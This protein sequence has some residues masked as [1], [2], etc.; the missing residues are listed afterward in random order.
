[1]QKLYLFTL[2]PWALL[3]QCIKIFLFVVVLTQMPRYGPLFHWKE[4]KVISA[5]ARVTLAPWALLQKCI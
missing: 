5:K 3:Q 1:M 4:L 2:A